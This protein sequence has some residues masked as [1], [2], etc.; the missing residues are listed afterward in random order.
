MS[1]PGFYSQADAVRDFQASRWDLL[2]VAADRIAR[3]A[4]AAIF[5]RYGT[6]SRRST[7]YSDA[8]AAGIEAAYLWNPPADFAKHVMTAVDKWHRQARYEHS[9]Q[10]HDL[11]FLAPVAEVRAGKGANP[12][13]SP[14]ELA[15]GWG[16]DSH[17]L[18]T[19]FGGSRAR[20]EGDEGE[21][22]YLWH[23][24][25]GP[26]AASPVVIEAFMTRGY[27]ERTVRLALAFEPYTRV[28]LRRYVDHDQRP[29]RGGYNDQD[30]LDFEREVMQARGL[31]DAFAALRPPDSAVSRLPLGAVRLEDIPNGLLLPPEYW[32]QT[33]EWKKQVERYV[34][35]FGDAQKMDERIPRP[36]IFTWLRDRYSLWS[37]MA[38]E[39][40]HRWDG[41]QMRLVRES[42]SG[43]TREQLPQVKAVLAVR[44]KKQLRKIEARTDVT[45]RW[46][47]RKIVQI[48][49]S[50]AKIG[51]CF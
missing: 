38:I 29:A 14:L 23:S 46:K 7:S 40:S 44:L 15:A 39:D 4:L 45:D 16:L 37:D 30:R 28:S 42:I 32:A 2:A 50:L 34:E 11:V 48:Q 47:L 18:D 36:A 6:A 9:K 31:L 5:S 24:T 21:L 33:L 17:D 35:L 51:A 1:K 13:S 19:S 12:I 49:E 10:P 25:I 26:A 20:P 22:P 41:M 43:L 3:G 8:K 27:S